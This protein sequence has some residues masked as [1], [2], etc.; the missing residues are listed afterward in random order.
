MTLGAPRAPSSTQSL[1][2]RMILSPGLPAARCISRPSS[3]RLTQSKSKRR[4]GE[5][6]SRRP[7]TD[8]EAAMICQAPIL[9][10]RID[11]MMSTPGVA[12]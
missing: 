7:R 5:R 12:T 4:A 2:Q 8:S 3:R 11:R 10:D 6:A 1:S 9:P